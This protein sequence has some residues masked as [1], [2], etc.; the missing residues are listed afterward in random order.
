M[1][2][3]FFDWINSSFFAKG[4]QA[5]KDLSNAV[6]TKLRLDADTEFD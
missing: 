2:I 6:E 1:F 5:T 3:E 4:F